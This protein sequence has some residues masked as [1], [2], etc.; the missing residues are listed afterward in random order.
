MD[1]RQSVQAYRAGIDAASFFIMFGFE[2]RKPR[3]RLL[4]AWVARGGAGSG[5]PIEKKRPAVTF[6]QCAQGFTSK[7]HRWHHTSES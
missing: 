6:K 4:M 3:G 1:K 7:M 2:N 5:T